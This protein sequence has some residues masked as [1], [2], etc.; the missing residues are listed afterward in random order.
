MSTE[1]TSTQDIINELIKFNVGTKKEILNAINHVINKHDIN[2]ITDYITNHQ[3]SVN[4][5]DS[6]VVK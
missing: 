2:E 4:D 3:Q 1:P 6:N 5:N